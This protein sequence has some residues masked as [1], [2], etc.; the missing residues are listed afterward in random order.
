MCVYF[1]WWSFHWNNICAVSDG[2]CQLTLWISNQHSNCLERSQISMVL[3]RV[4]FVEGEEVKR[5]LS[6]ASLPSQCLRWCRLK[7]DNGEELQGRGTAA[8]LM[9]KKQSKTS[10]VGLCTMAVLYLPTEKIHRCY[11]M[12]LHNCSMVK[13]PWD[14]LVINTHLTNTCNWCNLKCSLC[15]ADVFV[16]K[17]MFRHCRVRSYACQCFT[18]SA[19]DLEP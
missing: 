17:C 19:S 5:I 1:Y 15:I 9:K 11:L 4:E 14:F 10:L 7:G 6:R 12:S 13:L 16:L 3:F 8:V 2:W 18:S